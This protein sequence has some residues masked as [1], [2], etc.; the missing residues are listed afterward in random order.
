MKFCGVMGHNDMTCRMAQGVG[1][2]IEEMSYMGGYA[3][4]QPMNGP[5]SN[6]YYLGWQNHP[7]FSW[8]DPNITNQPRP[9]GPLDFQPR[10]PISSKSQPSSTLTFLTS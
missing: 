8:K 6:T 2:G 4:P 3:R 10:P 1:V 9:V 5:Y 7:K